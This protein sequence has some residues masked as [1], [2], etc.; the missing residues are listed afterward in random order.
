M[1]KLLLGLGVALLAGAA[2][3]VSAAPAVT[4]DYVEARSCNVYAGPCHFGSEYTTAG[5]EAVMAWHVSHGAY[6]G[7]T[8]DGLSAVAV[9]AAEENLA[10][11]DVPRRTAF[12]IDER[13]TPAQ[14][15]A[16]VALLRA[17]TGADFGRV[18]AVRSAP[19]AFAEE[20]DGVRVSVPKIA[21][22][23]ATK[24]PDAACCRWP[25]QRWYEPLARTQDVRVGNAALNEY[26]DSLLNVRWAQNGANSVLF[27]GFSF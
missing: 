14:R 23:T 21:R 17:K 18:V 4:G 20:S 15:D 5:R 26:E 22:L 8:L 27:G 19:V 7:Q 13:A 9:V 3:R 6:A 11:A 10:L 24:M 25:G 2:A 12:Y 1:N 16:M